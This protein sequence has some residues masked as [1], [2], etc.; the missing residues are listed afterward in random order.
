[1]DIADDG[2]N[3]VYNACNDV[4]EVVHAGRRCPALGPRFLKLFSARLATMNKPVL[5]SVGAVLAICVGLALIIPSGRSAVRGW[6]RPNPDARL[7]KIAALGEK[8]KSAVPEL[9]EALHDEDVK[10][11][12]AAGGV[13]GRM[14]PDALDAVPTLRDGQDENVWMA[15]V[16]QQMGDPAAVALGESLKDPDPIVRLNSAR[17]LQ[18]E[19]PHT[20][21]ALPALTAAL[22]DSDPE[23]REA[24]YVALRQVGPEAREALVQAIRQQGKAYSRAE[25]IVAIGKFGPEG[26]P[27]IPDLE[28]ALRDDSLRL[29]AIQTLGKIGPAAKTTLPAL[30][31]AFKDKDPQVRRA[32]LEAMGL[33]GRDS[34]PILLAA[35]KD[36]GL[37]AGAAAALGKIGRPAGVAVPTLCKMLEDPDAEVRRNA[38]AALGRI[39]PQT[40]EVIPALVKTLRDKEA[41]EQAANS[42]ARMGQPAVKP[43]I[44]ALADDQTRDRATSALSQIGR[45]AVP[46]VVELLKNDRL[47]LT[48]MQILG[49]IGGVAREAIPDL[50]AIAENQS[51]PARQDATMAIDKIKKSRTYAR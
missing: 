6:F 5:I 40:P 38:A 4:Q 11:R 43:L 35:L 20:K 39:G 36:D 29:A 17:A 50:T 51:D 48:A 12:T 26:E 27:A 44:A 19:G 3:L 7:K 21:A 2:G 14:G 24:V 13:L 30:E 22:G 16:L 15:V 25:I 37:R 47:R 33:I 9:I 49:Q 45:P 18:H 10:I 28:A 42:L 23:V 41:D 46:P 31:K 34:L 8:G 1:M 32:A